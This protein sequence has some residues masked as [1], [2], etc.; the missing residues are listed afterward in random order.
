[1]HHENEKIH[2]P[3]MNLSLLCGL[4]GRPALILITYVRFDRNMNNVQTGGLVAAPCTRE[5]PG[6][7]KIKK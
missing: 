1:M 4:G 5:Q 3:P 6:K 2:L 7:Q